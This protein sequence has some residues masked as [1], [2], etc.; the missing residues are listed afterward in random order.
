MIGMKAYTSREPFPRG[1][2]DD[3]GK[4]LQEFGAEFSVTI[5]VVDVWM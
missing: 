4:H 2:L 5:R 3:T 1:L